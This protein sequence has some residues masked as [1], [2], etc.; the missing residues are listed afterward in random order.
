MKA[1]AIRI[2]AVP[3]SGHPNSGL[4]ALY[5]AKHYGDDVWALPAAGSY[6][7][8]YLR[9]KFFFLDLNW[10][11]NIIPIRAIRA[12]Y[13][14]WMFV[15]ALLLPSRI[16]FIHSFI[17]ALPLWFLRKKY[18]IFIHGSDR[19]F[20]D[21]PWSQAV[22]CGAVAVFGV[23][24]GHRSDKFTVQE[25]PNI[26]IPATCNSQQHRETDVLFVL[27]NAPVKNPIYPITLSEKLGASLNLRINVIGVAARDLSPTDQTRLRHLK[28]QGQNINY[29][30]RRSYDEVVSLMAEC[31]ILMIPSFSEGIPKVL[32]EGMFQGMHIV[33][34]KTLMFPAEIMARVD[35]VALDDWDTITTTIVRQRTLERNDANISFA[36]QY[37]TLSQK[38]LLNLYDEIY[39]H[40]GDGIFHKISSP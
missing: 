18:C 13:L 15:R 27:R 39:A 4:Q 28:E 22:I 23:G 6:I 31:Y 30:G 33:I 8:D 32:L 20:L 9:V 40:H 2:T 37:L 34:N 36:R 26:F 38:S 16:F 19:R 29:L 1:R 5:F 7:G 3:R 11:K 10:V 24:F 21:M 12:A 17:F 14:F 35:S 25:V